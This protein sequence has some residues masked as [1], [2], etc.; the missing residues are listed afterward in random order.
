M[1]KLYFVAFIAILLA[2]GCVPF[3][4]LYPEQLE[5]KGLKPADFPDYILVSID[6]D[7]RLEK[8]V[9]EDNETDPLATADK[10]GVVKMTEKVILIDS[11]TPGIVEPG[12]VSGDKMKLNFGKPVGGKDEDPD[13]IIPVKRISGKST[14]S[15]S[16]DVYVLD[17]RSRGGDDPQT[18]IEVSGSW[19]IVTLGLK[20][21]VI[22]KQVKK[23]EEVKAKGKKPSGGD[24]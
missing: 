9:L 3:K 23:V 20:A 1:K 16:D 13:I 21:K 10:S 11:K 15:F 22:Y 4:V 14:E 8:D 19:Y 5:E 2:S 7:I 17:L 24:N 12:S 6:Q 18:R